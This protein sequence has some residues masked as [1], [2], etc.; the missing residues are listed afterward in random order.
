MY[1]KTY[2]KE[3]GDN[4]IIF[5]NKAVKMGFAPP[6]STIAFWQYT[7]LY[8]RVGSD[9]NTLGGGGGVS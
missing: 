1:P 9:F 5:V 6:H 3:G 4:H 8:T 7:L 2:V